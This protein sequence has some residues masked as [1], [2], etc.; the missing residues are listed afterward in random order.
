MVE[1]KIFY[2]GFENFSCFS[3]SLKIAISFKLWYILIGDTM[4]HKKIILL[5]IILIVLMIVIGI[6]LIPR[7][8]EE[9]KLISVSVN[10]LETKMN[11]QETFI[12]VISQ[13]GCSHCQQYLPELDRTLKDLDLNAYV[14]NISNINEEENTTLNK[15]VHFSGTP[16][17]IF[18]TEGTEATTLNRIVGYASKTKIMERLKSLGYT[19]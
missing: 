14:L 15:Y 17:T 1:M 9:S 2:T 10:E 6:F 5:L 16:T 8:K 3:F 4:K 13:T 19:D 18:I 7:N 12:L 11:N